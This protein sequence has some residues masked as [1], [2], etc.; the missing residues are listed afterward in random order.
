MVVFVFKLHERLRLD[1][2]RVVALIDIVQSR[3]DLNLEPISRHKVEVDTLISS[4][5]SRGKWDGHG[6]TQRRK[7]CVSQK[8]A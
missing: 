2:L 1:E 4:H 8:L 7:L 3:D 6:M 5:A